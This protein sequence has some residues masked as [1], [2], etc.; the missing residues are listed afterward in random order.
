MKII[1]RT[2]IFHF[3]CIII[4]GLIYLNLREDYNQPHH[5][6]KKLID[7][8]FLST[9]IQAGVG[10]SDMYPSNFYGKIFMM[11]QQIIMILANI[12]TLYIFSL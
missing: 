1:F 12:I 8:F 10:M 3:I 11:I 7:F 6:K 9:T 4:F 2:A 5:K